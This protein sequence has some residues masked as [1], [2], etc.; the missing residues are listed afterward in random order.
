MD[1]WV[2]KMWYIDTIEY[3]SRTKKNEIPPFATTW[4]EPEGIGLSEM[5]QTEKDKYCMVLLIRGI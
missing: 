4:R 5:S 3:Y 2:K 1:E